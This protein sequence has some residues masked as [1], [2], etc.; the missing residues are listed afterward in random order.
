MEPPPRVD[1]SWFGILYGG[2]AEESP[3][4]SPKMRPQY[5]YACMVPLIRIEKGTGMDKQWEIRSSCRYRLEG[6]FLSK[7]VC[8]PLVHMIF[9][10]KYEK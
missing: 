6:M 10:E 4:R 9:L 5:C 8:P 7:K 2:L 1:E 3:G